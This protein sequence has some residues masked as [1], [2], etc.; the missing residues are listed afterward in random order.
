VIHRATAPEAAE[1][2]LQARDLAC[3]GSSSTL[4][5]TLTGFGTRF[6]RSLVREYGG[7]LATKPRDPKR[8]LREPRL[9]AHVPYVVLFYE[10]QRATMSVPERLLDTFYSYRTHARPPLLDVNQCAQII[11]LYETNNLWE[12]TCTKCPLTYFVLSEEPL[13]PKCRLK[14]QAFCKKCGLQKRRV[15][16]H[17]RVYC[18]ACSSAIAKRAEKDPVRQALLATVTRIEVVPSGGV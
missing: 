12:R 10:Y 5:E 17:A 14:E 1:R 2:V 13:C 16:S 6:V 15:D 9:L 7:A 18:D 3:A 4:I 8:W 11:D